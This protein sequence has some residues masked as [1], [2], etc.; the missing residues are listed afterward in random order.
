SA[1][2][3]GT[4]AGPLLQQLGIYDEFVELAKHATKMDIYNGNLKHA[5]TMDYGWL[6]K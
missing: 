6:E 4:G 3:L 5:F 2:I 1:M